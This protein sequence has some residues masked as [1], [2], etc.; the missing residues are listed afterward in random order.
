MLELIALTALIGLAEEN[1]CERLVRV[2][3]G[4]IEIPCDYR[5]VHTG[6]RIDYEFGYIEP[7]GG[8]WRIHWSSG[9]VANKLSFS[10]NELK[11]FLKRLKDELQ[12]AESDRASMIDFFANKQESL[13]GKS[14][15][16]V[17]FDQS[18]QVLQQLFHYI[19]SSVAKK[20]EA[21]EYVH[22]LKENLRS[23]KI[24]FEEMR[25]ITRQ[26]NI[27]KV[28]SK[29]EI[30]REVALSDNITA[31]SEMFEQL[32]QKMDE[33]IS[34]IRSQLEY[35]NQNIIVSLEK[36]EQNLERQESNIKTV[37][38]DIEAS[39][40]NLSTIRDKL[41]GAISTMGQSSGHLNDLI[42]DS[43]KGAQKID[44]L[45]NKSQHLGSRYGSIF[46]HLDSYRKVATNEYPEIFNRSFE[47]SRFPDLVEIAKK[48][49]A[50]DD[51]VVT[52]EIFE[53][54]NETNDHADDLVLF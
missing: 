54:E 35:I 30:A 12:D 23:I 19:K 5:V 42:H 21:G 25:S 16:E 18:S 36:L 31:S 17:I 8:V 20:R 13:D 22:I 37:E 4:C 24:S 52:A 46:S 33:N 10:V 49:L 1:H 3:P 53:P 44:N 9:M 45:I 41:N 34:V 39:I 43:L 14:S 29:V 28:V 48:F 26:F 40:V 2:M 27:I 47:V 6:G 15:I 7:P 38:T 32:T 11:I 51:S 50:C